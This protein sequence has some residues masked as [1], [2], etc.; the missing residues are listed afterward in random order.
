ML[1]LLR[2]AQ[3]RHVLRRPI[4]RECVQLARSLGL[5]GFAQALDQR[6]PRQHGKAPSLV[7]GPVVRRPFGMFRVERQ[8]GLARGLDDIAADAHRRFQFRDVGKGERDRAGQHRQNDFAVQIDVVGARAQVQCAGD[9]GRIVA[10]H[11]SCGEGGVK[12]RLGTGRRAGHA[13]TVRRIA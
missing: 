7:V 10:R 8:R 13:G 1:Q 2:N 5:R 4:A 9:A 3:N 12:P 6:S 11:A